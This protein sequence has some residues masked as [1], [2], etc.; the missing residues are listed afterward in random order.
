MKKHSR[1]TIAEG[2]ER[3]QPWFH[4]IDLAGQDTDPNNPDHPRARWKVIHADFPGQMQG[5]TVLD[6]GC[7]SGY[8]SLELSALGARVLAVDWEERAIAQVSFAAEVLGLDIEC[9]LQNI[10]EFVLANDQ[11]FDYVLFMGVFY[12]LR[13]PLLVTDQLA[14][15]TREA[16][17]F[18]TVLSNHEDT[19]D[20]ELPDNFSD[21]SLLATPG[22]PAMYFLERRFGGILNNWFVCNESAV[23]AMLRSSG[24]HPPQKRGE[25]CFVCKPDHAALTSDHP[26]WDLHAIRRFATS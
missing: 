13:H 16:L 7:A 22:F 1:K 23:R 6:L 21:R 25:D 19:V 5:K 9:R 15:M 8:F 20:P 4:N 11:V 12:H 14:R 17:F 2:I 26:A 3:L 18:Q 24:F 10:Y